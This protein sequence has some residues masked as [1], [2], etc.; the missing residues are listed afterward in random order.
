MPYPIPKLFQV[1][2]A[3]SFNAQ[4]PEAGGLAMKLAFRLMMQLQGHRQLLGRS[5]IEDDEVAVSLG[6]GKWVDSETYNRARAQQ[7]LRRNAWRFVE[8]NDDHEYPEPL[9][10]NLQT[11]A[12]M[13]GL[14]EVERDILGFCAL[15]HSDSLLN[16]CFNLFGVI[17]NRRLTQVLAVMLERPVEAVARALEQ[18]GRLIASGLLSVS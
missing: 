2:V 7:Q 5:A 9:R 6:L 13:L 1:P 3:P 10:D 12:Q 4:Q 17:D 16:R 14:D 8:D 11:L 18:D 15:L